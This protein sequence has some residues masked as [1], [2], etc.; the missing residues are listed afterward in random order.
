MYPILVTFEVLN[1]LTFITFNASHD[2]NIFLM[3]VTREVSNL[4][5]SISSNFLQLLNID[6]MFSTL[7]VTILFILR[8]DKDSQF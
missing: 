7:D 2:S 4:D 3:F 5:K 6:S 1:L 8:E